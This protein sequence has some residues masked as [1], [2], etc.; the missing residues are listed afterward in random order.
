VPGPR[1]QSA[2]AAAL[3]VD[4]GTLAEA[5]GTVAHRPSTVTES[6]RLA[7]GWTLTTLAEHAGVAVTAVR[8]LER[9][10]PVR[11]GT[12][13]AVAS[14]LGVPPAD[15]AARVRP[16][17][18]GDG[19]QSRFSALVS[20]ALAARAWTAADLAAHL[21]V[22]RQQLSAWR[23]GVDPVPGRYVPALA[24]LFG[25]PP[26]ELSQLLAAE[27]AHRPAAAAAGRRAAARRALG[28]RQRDVASSAGIAHT[29]YTRWECGRGYLREQSLSAVAEVLGVPVEQ[30][31]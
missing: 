26:A 24:E 13:A 18:A 11:P 7:R 4:A 28:L 31:R 14:T 6:L 10:K 9:G 29:T 16:G 5:F 25:M 21:S 8:R 27:W 30:L 12:V 15:L 19:G 3:G 22:H 1:H 2:L 17:R 20:A 23:A